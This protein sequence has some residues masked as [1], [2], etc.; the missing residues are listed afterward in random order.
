MEERLTNVV[1]L[2]LLLRCFNSLSTRTFFQ[3]D[4]YWQ[5]LEIAH[6]IAFKYGYQ[7]WEWRNLLGQG[8]IRSPLYPMLFVPLY[9]ALDWFSLDQTALLVSSPFL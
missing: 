1:L 7:T 6:S 3:P 4:E 8:G 5:S 9:A 2:S